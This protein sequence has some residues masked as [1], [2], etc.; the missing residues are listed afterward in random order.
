MILNFTHEFGDLHVLIYNQHAYYK[1]DDLMTGLTLIDKADTLGRLNPTAI[2]CLPHRAKYKTEYVKHEW[3]DTCLE[4]ARNPKAYKF[5][6]WVWKEV[7]PVIRKKLAETKAAPAVKTE[8]PTTDLVAMANEPVHSYN[9]ADSGVQVF[10]SEMFGDLRGLMIDDEPWFVGKDVCKSLGDTNHNRSLGRIAE[11]DKRTIPMTDSFGRKCSA[12]AI[13][14]PG[15]YKLLLT[16]EPNKANKGG[17]RNAYSV[18]TEQRIEK[19][20]QFKR[21]VTHDVLPSIRKT[22]GYIKGEEH[23]TDDELIAKAL[24]MVNEKLKLREQENERL[25]AQIDANAP[26]VLFADAVEDRG[27]N[28]GLADFAKMLYS[29]DTKIG[30]TRLI[31]WLR[32]KGY[33]MVDKPR[34]YQRFIEQKLFTL[35]HKELSNGNIVVVTLITPKGQIALTNAFKVA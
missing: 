3:V 29:D 4:L 1:L 5:R 26:K 11:E 14:E 25:Q 21:W 32:D 35:R 9:D 20:H 12:I 28:V 22:G 17:V 10:H 33:F 15:L 23:M 27:D 24:L 30:R 8:A 6:S 16:M 7:K 19:L 31:Q 34:P 13:N 2:T 18:E